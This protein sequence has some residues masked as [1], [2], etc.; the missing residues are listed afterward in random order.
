MHLTD[1]F[2]PLIVRDLVLVVWRGFGSSKARASCTFSQDSE[3]HLY[4]SDDMERNCH[5]LLICMMYSWML[6]KNVRSNSHVYWRWV[7]L[8][9]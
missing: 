4:L 7:E 2:S 8:P 5:L 1:C 3:K 9:G 6:L